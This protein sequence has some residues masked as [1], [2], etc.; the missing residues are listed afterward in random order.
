LGKDWV[1]H[2]DIDAAG[3]NIPG[4]KDAERAKYGLGFV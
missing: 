1:Y 4:S 3:C 2:S